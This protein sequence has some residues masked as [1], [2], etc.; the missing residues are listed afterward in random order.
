VAVQ[1]D[2]FQAP[3]GDVS[4]DR[5][6]R[7]REFLARHGGAGAARKTGEDRSGLR[8]WYEIYAADGH[9]LRCDWTRSGSGAELRYSEIAP[10][11]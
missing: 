11:S 4:P 1:Q 9:A 3:D 5:E 7:I 8:G 6:D 10:R 2:E